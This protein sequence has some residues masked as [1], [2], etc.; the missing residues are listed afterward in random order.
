MQNAT[1][2][3]NVHTFKPNNTAFKKVEEI[4]DYSCLNTNSADELD[5]QVLK[6]ETIYQLQ[7]SRAPQEAH[8]KE[9][10]EPGGL[11]T[12]LLPTATALATRFCSQLPPHAAKHGCIASS[13]WLAL[14]FPFA[15]SNFSYLPPLVFSERG[16]MKIPTGL[17]LAFPSSAFPSGGSA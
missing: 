13:L 15:F 4:E 2:E 11:L 10:P 1:T 6:E 12:C 5:M 7:H 14:P 3:G 9:P 8:P 17:L 16:L